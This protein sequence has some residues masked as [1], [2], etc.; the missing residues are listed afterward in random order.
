M[1]TTSGIPILF[2]FQIIMATLKNL[3]GIPNLSQDCSLSSI[4]QL[5]KCCPPTIDLVLDHYEQ[6]IQCGLHDWREI[7][8]DT[9]KCKS[10]YQIIS[11]FMNMLI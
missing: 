5:I 10:M 1:K 4:M 3:I 7:V 6:C 2:F 8:D 11:I 9:G